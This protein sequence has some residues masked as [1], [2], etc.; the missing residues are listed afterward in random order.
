MERTKD[1]WYTHRAVEEWVSEYPECSVYAQFKNNAQ[2]YLSFPA[3]VFQN[4]TYSY[5]ETINHIEKLSTALYAYGVQKGDIVSIISPNVPQAVFMFYALNRIGAVANMIHPLLAAKE[6]QQLV[7]KVQSKAVF[8]LDAVYDKIAAL[9]WKIPAKPKVIVARVKDALPGWMKPLYAMK[10]RQKLILNPA[11]ESILW[12]D[13]LKLADGKNDVLP[14][15]TGAAGDMAAILYTGGTTGVP[16]GAMF[17]NYSLTCYT[18]QISE[19]CGIRLEGKR[20]L[21]VLPLFH[22]FGLALNILV[23][24]AG[25]SCIYLVPT[26]DFHAC[27]SL[28]FKKRLNVI[29]GV[30]AFFESLSRYPKMENSDLS[31]IEALVSGGDVLNEK[32]RNRL[33]KQLKTGGA[34]YPV[35]NGY[36]QT[37][38]LAGVCI[39]PIFKN[40]IGSVGLPCP[41]VKAKI[42]EI[43]TCTE[44]ENGI[45]GELCL[46]SPNLTLGYYQ[47]AE[48]T[49]HIL[50]KHDDGR[51]WLHT[52]DI[53]CKDDDGYL[54]FRQRIKRMIISAGYNIYLSQVETVVSQCSVVKQCCAVG[55]NDKVAG[56][57]VG[58]WVVLSGN[59]SEDAAKAAIIECCNEHLAAFSQPRK[60]VFTE[61]LPKTKMGK[62]DFKLLED[63]MNNR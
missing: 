51:I 5:Q 11:H 56:Q 23:M 30:P 36:G 31:F 45:D 34:K 9:E 33:D 39:N 28:I 10:N 46:Y 26:Y 32:L 20:C 55:I 41:D 54:F 37:E 15:D 25:G 27:S 21:A 58:L 17:C 29:Y 50:K 13:L 63:R 44:V 48:A 2:Q 35:R 14:P 43:G 61:E 8:V 12:N 4:K 62:V 52:G 57:Y 38:C 53:F 49:A 1:I 24:L 3:I 22:G 42:V 18:I 40:K 16:K 6:I 19:A 47:D 60:I 59:M 7:E